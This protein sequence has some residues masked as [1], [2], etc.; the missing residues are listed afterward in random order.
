MTVF[1]HK[2]PL[3]Y[4]IV[5]DHYGF[6]GG[7]VVVESGYKLRLVDTVMGKIAKDIFSKYQGQN[8]F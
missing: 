1:A 7:S 4:I 8:H 5:T 6:Y 2:L 3:L